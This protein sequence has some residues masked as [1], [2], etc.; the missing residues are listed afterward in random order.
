VTFASALFELLRRSNPQLPSVYEI[1]SKL[2]Q[3]QRTR[4]AEA[5]KR[6]R[7]GILFSSDVTARGMDFP[8]VSHV[9][10]IGLPPDRE[11]YIHRIG[12]TGRA[13]KGGQGW[14]IVAENE[15]DAARNTLPGLPIQRAKGDWESPNHDLANPHAPSTPDTVTQISKATRQIP[16]QVLAEAYM[17]CLSIPNRGDMQG[18]VDNLNR[19]ARLGWGWDEPPAVDRHTARMRGLTRLRGMNISDDRGRESRDSGRDERRPHRRFGGDRFGELEDSSPRPQRW[20]RRT[21]F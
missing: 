10:Q 14:L 21:S 16:R 8:N 3:H 15:I 11:Q 19:W 2:T 18:L 9:I 1:H 6:A 20:T 5:F 13:N 17:S 12:R 7:S 4:A